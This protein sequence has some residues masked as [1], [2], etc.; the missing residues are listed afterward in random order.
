MQKTLF[1]LTLLLGLLVLSSATIAS[2]QDKTVVTYWTWNAAAYGNPGQMVNDQPSVSFAQE[3]FEAAHPEIDLDVKILSYND[4]LNQLQL[5]MAAGTGPDIVALQAGVLLN[6][7]SEFL[8]DL[9]PNAQ[10]EWGDQWADRFLALG[11]DQS[12]TDAGL[13]GLPLMN[14]AAGFLWY[15][16]TIF[17]TNGLTPPTNWEEWVAT[18]TALSDAGTIGFYHGAADSW[19]NLDMII[20]I[21]NEIAPGKIYEAE[22]GSIPWTDPDLVKAMDYWKQ[23]FSNGIMQEGALAATQYPDTHQ[24]YTSGK[25]GMMLMGVWNDFSVLTKAGVEGSKQGYGFTEDYDYATIPFPDLNGDG[26]TGVPFGGPDVIVAMNGTSQ[27]QDAAWTVL[28]W[29]VSE[30]GQMQQA[31]LLNVPSIKGVPFDDSDATGDFAKQVLE[32]QI[33]QLESASGKREFIYPDLKTA[34]SDAL[35]S[36]A[37]GLQTPEEAMAAIEAVSQTIER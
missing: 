31:K 26:K 2:A 30:E 16:K 18:S 28:S 25:A 23:M 34:L 13:M 9:T 35:Q 8:V 14:S 33:T 32:D 12:K 24:N 22:A 17:D 15:N 7:Y 6:T 36:V 19:V 21:A 5:N 27:N 37:A 20:S 1:R 29:M 10:A 4:Y 11:L 3:A